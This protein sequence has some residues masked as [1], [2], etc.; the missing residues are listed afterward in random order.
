MFEVIYCS[1]TGNT[2]KVAESI[3]GELGV[4][5]EDVISKKSLGK[6]SAVFLGSGNYGGK[7]GKELTDFIEKNNF[8]GRC[9]FVFG[10]SG[11]GKG[12]EVKALAEMLRNKGAKVEDHF[13][14]RG[15]FIVMFSFGHPN[16]KDLEKARMFARNAK[17]NA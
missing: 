1:K 11:S 7:P 10:T 17:K 14:C 4:K 15:A 9:V 6:S 13:F 3:A 5:A 16:G 8:K 2:K 12:V